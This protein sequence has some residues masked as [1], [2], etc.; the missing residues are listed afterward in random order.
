[1]ILARQEI[2]L[3]KQD[4]M[5]E[6]D[7]SCKLQ[8]KD[9]TDSCLVFFSQ[10]HKPRGAKKGQLW[11]LWQFFRKKLKW[12][13][14]ECFKNIGFFGALIFILT[15]ESPKIFKIWKRNNLY[16]NHYVGR[17]CNFRKFRNEIILGTIGVDGFI[18]RKWRKIWKTCV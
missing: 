1:M 6:K 16:F 17:N 5:Q 12:L 3:V 2:S 9:S 14:S 11:P 10:N 7:V 13:K 18:K 8:D 15:T 4:P